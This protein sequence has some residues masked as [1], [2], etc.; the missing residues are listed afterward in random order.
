MK[1][2]KEHNGKMI[3]KFNSLQS[4]EFYDILNITK[5][6]QGRRWVP[7]AQSWEV[8]ISSKN[9][10]LFDELGF[11]ID[12]SLRK[13]L[14]Q[15][16]EKVEKIKVEVSN[17]KSEILYD[18][19]YDHTKIL[20]SDLMNNGAALDASDTGTG[21]TFCALEIAKYFNL[22]PIVITP[23]SVIPIWYKV[24]KTVGI[25]NIFVSNYEQ[26]RIGKSE[27]LKVIE[28]EDDK[29]DFIWQVSDKYILIW[30]EVHRAKNQKT[31][32]AKMLLSAKNTG[33]KNLCLSATIADNPLQ[34][35]ALGIILG[36][37]SNAGEFWR[38][39][40]TRGVSKGWFGYEFTSSPETLNKIHRD[41]FPERGHR[42]A[43]KD[44]GDKF[45]DNLIIV[46]TYDMNSAGNKIQNVYATMKEEL[47]R[48]SE[49]K[50]EDGSSILTEVL[51]ARQE[52]ELLKVPTFVEL[53]EDAIEEGSSV[54]IFVNFEETVIA[55]KQKL[56]T[57]C[58]LTGKITGEA[59]EKNIEEFQSDRSRVIICNIRAGGVG[60]SLHDLNGIYPRISLI[61]PTPSAQDLKQVF[62]RI[63]RAGGKSKAIQKIIFC[64]ETIEESIAERVQEKM[65]NMDTINDGDLEAL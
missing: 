41:I 15:T 39:A 28:K 34:L 57:D 9:V 54:A 55:L 38:W 8:P 33:V 7:A 19:Q 32:N 14:V 27:F 2:A 25:K 43:I 58:I 30:D 6:L 62:G 51:R 21:K 63:H 17:F 20:I 37:F 10:E 13:H 56:K 22:I 3:I 60:V 59:R 53:A 40:F 42:I 64:A 23:K 5:A 11:E 35:Y 36:L 47:Q 31:Q 1:T 16:K 50:K 46:D 65:K 61:S 24:A 26:F 18:Y 4:E 29:K 45:P 49:I 48:L 12:S 52:I 44:L